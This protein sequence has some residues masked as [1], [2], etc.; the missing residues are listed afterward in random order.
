MVGSPS[1][2]NRAGHTQ[3]TYR[4]DQTSGVISINNATPA[5]THTITIR[6][7]DNC[8]AT[9][10]TS[11]TLTVGKANQTITFGAL[12]NKNVGDPDFSV[13]ATATSG[14]RVSFAASGQCTVNS[15]TVHITGAGSC[16]IT[17]SQAG[18]SNFNPAPEVQQS[19]TIVNSTNSSSITLSQAN[20]NVNES[21]G[22]VTVVVNRTGDLSS[23]VSVDYATDD[24][25]SSNICSALNSGLASSR[26]D[27]G[28]TLGTLLF[29][30]NDTQKT[31][32]IPITQDSYTEGPETFTVNLSNLNGNGTNF[33]T[34]SSAIVTIADGTTQLP[35][36]AS[37]DTE[38]FVRQ[39]YHDF[40]NREA[41]PAG[42]AF[43]TG[44]INNCTPKPQC[45]QLKRINVSAAF[46]L[47]IEFQTTGNLVRNFY[48]AAFDR[49]ATNNMP[50]FVE[51]ERD[52]Q[53]MQRGVIVDPNNDAFQTVVEQQS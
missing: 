43:W 3:V 2:S 22:F 44:E 13:N 25:G 6:A 10:D 19:F 48:V 34:P 7:T 50:A 26:C 24:T 8:G 53:A 37:D 11:F 14:L 12:A 20:Y 23:P 45:T 4:V 38:A 30:P 1:S 5:G 18:D 36:N 28:L 15:N 41:D 42:L 32:I 27:F 51:F 49:P 31:F 39:Q 21:T 16:T 40:L 52:T 47:S 35:P 46:F 17:A 33:G 9:T 29:A